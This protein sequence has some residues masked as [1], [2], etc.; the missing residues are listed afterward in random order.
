MGQN[1]TKAE[2]CSNQFSQGVRLSTLFSPG[3]RLSPWPLSATATCS[4]QQANCFTIAHYC[5]QYD[6]N[7]DH[8][9]DYNHHCDHWPIWPSPPP[10]LGKLIGTCCAISGVLVM[11]L[12]IP[13]I[14]NNFAEFYNDQVF[15][16]VSSLWS[17]ICPDFCHCC[18][19]HPTPR[20]ALFVRPSVRNV[21]YPI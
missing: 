20:N 6:H 13:I 14:V 21:F 11:A 17:F 15:I 1:V 12:P 18:H 4:P 10:G 9:Y 7:I 2:N 16:S 3:G 19:P 8:H 5:D